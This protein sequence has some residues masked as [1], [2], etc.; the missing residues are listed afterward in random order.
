M[1]ARVPASAVNTSGV[2]N[3]G[4]AE[5]VVISTAPISVPLDG[6]T[7]I[8]LASVLLN[9]PASTTAILYKI[10]RGITTGLANLL[11]NNALPD[12]PAIGVVQRTFCVTDNP[13]GLA[14]VQY[15]LT[16]T[17]TGAVSSGNTP[18]LFIA[19]FCL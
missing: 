7:V 16:M 13:V 2:S 8:I 15:S 5:G 11:S 10:V 3:I 4:S 14:S 12:T 19:V 18:Q 17:C 9:V 1:G 6:A